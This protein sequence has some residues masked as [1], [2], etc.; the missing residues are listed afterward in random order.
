LAEDYFSRFPIKK[1]ETK[2]GLCR[3]TIFEAN[4]N[5]FDPNEVRRFYL[6]HNWGFMYR[7][8]GYGWWDILEA[9]RRAKNKSNN[10]SY[11]RASA[12]LYLRIDKDKIPI[13]DVEIGYGSRV[14]DHLYLADTVGIR[15]QEEGRMK[16]ADYFQVVGGI[17]FADIEKVIQRLKG[18]KGTIYIAGNG[19]SACT[20]NHFATDLV[21]NSGVKALSLCGNIGLLTAL[22][23]DYGFEFVFSKQLEGF[24]ISD[25]VLVI[26]SVSGNSPN[27]L[28]AVVAAKEKK[29]QVVGLLG[30]NG[31]GLVGSYCDLVVPISGD[32]Y[33]NCEDSH[34]SICHSIAQALR[35]KQ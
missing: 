32:D 22:G 28:N 29:M 17:T 12:I 7:G 21:K 10:D 16:V 23:N 1:E 18:L 9:I 14:F 20:A 4:L 31:T 11:F 3:N 8:N 6:S 13:G 5:F 30:R 27:L 2:I 34:L 33:E 35:G 24:A 25:D 19:G 26:I 15:E